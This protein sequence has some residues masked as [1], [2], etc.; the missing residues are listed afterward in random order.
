VTDSA[1]GPG[2][3]VV[4][5]ADVEP[6]RVS[7]LWKGYLPLGKLVVHDGDPGV[8]KSTV[9]LDWAARVTTSSPMPD[10]SPGIK[11]TVLALSAEDGLADTIRPR[12]DAAGARPGPRHHHHG[13]RGRRR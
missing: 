13:D 11:R 9:S 10:G 12:L 1:A 3:R 4:S 2:P 8:V 7:W 5:L 6:E